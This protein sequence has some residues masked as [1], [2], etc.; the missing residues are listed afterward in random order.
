YLRD[1]YD[2][3][4]VMPR[5]QFERDFILVKN[6]KTDNQ[7][8]AAGYIRKIRAMLVAGGNK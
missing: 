8:R 3:E 4:C 7:R 1:G 2:F 5:Q 6:C